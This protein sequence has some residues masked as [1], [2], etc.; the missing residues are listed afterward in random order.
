MCAHLPCNAC[1]TQ[2]SKTGDIDMAIKAG[3]NEHTDEG[4]RVASDGA[5]GVLVTGMFS[6]TAEFGSTSL[7]SIGSFDI[8]AMHV[9]SSGAISWAVGM[10]GNAGDF[11]GDITPDGAGGALVT[12]NFKESATFG[13]TTLT[14][15]GHSDIFV[16]HVTSARAGDALTLCTLCCASA[17]CD[18]LATDVR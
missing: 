7:T 4:K 1:V 5:G 18:D 3:G 8:F 2:V 14:T 13:S 6:Q 16:M 17:P 12:G 11:A 15:S 9:T 10:G